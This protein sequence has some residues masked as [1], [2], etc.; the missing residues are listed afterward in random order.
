MSSHK[1]IHADRRL[2]ALHARQHRKHGA[3]QQQRDQQL[4]NSVRVALVRD[5]DAVANAQSRLHVA[6]LLLE[7]GAISDG[8]VE[9]IGLV[10]TALD[11]GAVV[12]N[13]GDQIHVRADDDLAHLALGE[14]VVDELVPGDVPGVI[15]QSK[16]VW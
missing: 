15:K 2:E 13:N 4:R 6:Q 14:H 9:H 8:H 5:G 7:F 1:R 12:Q 3:R 10:L 16:F 11:D